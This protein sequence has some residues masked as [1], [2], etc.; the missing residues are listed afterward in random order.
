MRL[1]ER[2]PDKIYKTTTI[3]IRTDLLRLAKL[4]GLVL[5]AV[6]E[7]A[8]LRVLPSSEIALEEK[9]ELERKLKEVD[10]KLMGYDKYGAMVNKNEN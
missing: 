5:R 8:L 9:M 1:V 10:A 3:E 2:N 7:D 4:K 6:L